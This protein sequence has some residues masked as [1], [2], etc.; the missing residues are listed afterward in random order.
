MD[1]LSSQVAGIFRRYQAE[2]RRMDRLSDSEYEQAI[3]PFRKEVA[4]LIAEHG[5]EAVVRT[6]LALSTKPLSLH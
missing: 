4:A 6:A 5:R 3:Q 1:D 2:F